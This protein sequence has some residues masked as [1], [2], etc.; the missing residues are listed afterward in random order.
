MTCTLRPD[1]AFLAPPLS[2]ARPR[3]DPDLFG[4]LMLEVVTP[5]G[6]ACAPDLPGWELRAWPVARLGDATLEAR[7]HRPGL[8]AA[9]LVEALHRA[10]YTPLG[11]VRTARGRERDA[12]L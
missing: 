1:P 10:G 7:P 5:D 8:G 9:E 4:T 6:Q 2:P 12:V 11:P 3:P